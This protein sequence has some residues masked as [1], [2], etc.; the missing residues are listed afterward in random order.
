MGAASTS[1]GRLSAFD[2]MPEEADGII[3]W[4]SAALANRTLT[5]SEIY[6]EFVEQCDALMAEHRGEI[7]FVI[8]SLSSFNRYSTRLARLTR[9]L[10]QTRNIVAALSDRFDPKE[11]DDLTVMTTETIKSLVLHM[12]AEADEDKLDAKDVM[13]MASAFRQALQAQNISTDRR[14]KAEAQ[15]A[16]RIDGAVDAVAKAKGLTAETSEAIKAQILGVG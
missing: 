10:D 7:E 5:Q 12:L 1:R 9:R 6:A 3:T 14:T 2:T 8:P 4:A 13:H 11:S 16:D 15:F